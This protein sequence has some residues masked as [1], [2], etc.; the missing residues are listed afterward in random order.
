M[1]AVTIV[2]EYINLSDRFE[3]LTNTFNI[4]V[5][6]AV[7]Y[8]INA[9]EFFSE[10]TASASD[11]VSSDSGTQLT[12][13]VFTKNG[14]SYKVNPYA[15][16]MYFNSEMLPLDS[17]V[18]S[19]MPS[20][21]P[22]NKLKTSTVY[23]WLY[24]KTGFNWTLI[25]ASKN[26]LSSNTLNKY[27]NAAST[28]TSDAITNY[29]GISSSGTVS[30]LT[31]TTSGVFTSSTRT[32]SND[33]QAFYNAMGKHITVN[34]NAKV[35]S[36]SSFN[37]ESKSYP[38][39]YNMGLAL[40]QDSLGYSMQ[41]WQS[42]PKLGK[43]NSIYYLTPNSLGVT[44][45]PLKMVY[46]TLVNTLTSSVVCSK[47]AEGNVNPTANTAASINIVKSAFG[48]TDSSHTGTN[49][50]IINDG[51][52]EYDLGSLNVSVQYFLYDFAGVVTTK[53]DFMYQLAQTTAWTS[54]T[55][56]NYSKE[57]K[58]YMLSHLATA[59]TTNR[60]VAKVTASI[61]VYVPYQCDFIKFGN[62]QGYTGATQ[63]YSIRPFDNNANKMVTGKDGFWYEYSTYRISY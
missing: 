20:G 3:S 24:G 45:V 15:Y 31:Y 49:A 38:I 48:C 50:N 44:Y 62:R 32:P 46:P 57:N 13:M 60:I 58:N 26:G 18:M 27:Q 12:M 51:D 43:D 29:N 10:Q 21:L 55:Y 56:A 1:F 61:K 14:Y 22:S 25:N 23:S 19:T 52:I 41:N 7:D 2:Y 16:A 47:L 30:Q 8:S 34:G 33:F 40:G 5:E 39:L 9:E 54:G 4:A 42:V 36:G 37:M 6:S 17:Y 11:N 59:N 28:A 53:H 63:H 35:W